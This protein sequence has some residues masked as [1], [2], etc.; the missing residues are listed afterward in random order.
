MKSSNG[1]YRNPKAQTKWAAYGVFAVE[2]ERC[3][4]VAPSYEWFAKRIADR[5]HQTMVRA[6]KGRRA[7]YGLSTRTP[8]QLNL[9]HGDAPWQVA[10][11]D[12]TQVDLECRYSDKSDRPWLTV[13]ICGYSR[14][15][16]GLVSDLR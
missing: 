16:P 3:G 13:M 11:A 8:G 5:D 10:Y 14:R 2:C 12:H 9:N 1:R 6:R 4:I 7:A 15:V